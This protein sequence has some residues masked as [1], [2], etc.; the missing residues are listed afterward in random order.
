MSSAEAPFAGRRPPLRAAVAAFAVAAAMFAGACTVQPLYGGGSLTGPAAGGMA[1]TLAAVS[2]D[3]VTTRQ[4]LEVR[5]HLIFLLSGGAGNPAD[6][7]YDMALAVSSSSS[8]AAT[9]QISTTEQAPSSSLLNMTAFYTLKA[10]AT[11]EIVARGTRRI[12]SAYDV[13]RQQY[14]ALRAQRDAENRAAR[15]LAEQLRFAVAQDLSR[16]N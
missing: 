3:P 11:G 4:G 16:R 15:E 8:S 12:S 13:P 2:V 6:P 5:N 10:R 14:A 1:A 9:I 7:G